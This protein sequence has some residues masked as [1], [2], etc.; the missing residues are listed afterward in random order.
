MFL[1]GAKKNAQ[2]LT[3]AQLDEVE[4]YFVKIYPDGIDES[5]INHIF[6][7]NFDQICVWLGIK[8]IL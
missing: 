1:S 8:D 7:F 5:T 6:W 2:K 4:R 3:L